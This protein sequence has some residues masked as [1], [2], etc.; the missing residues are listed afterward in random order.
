MLPEQLEKRPSID[1]EKSLA[2][3][4]HAQLKKFQ[5][6]L[7]DERFKGKLELGNPQSESRWN[8]T[9]PEEVAACFKPEFSFQAD[10]ITE[11]SLRIDDSNKINGGLSLHLEL[12]RNNQSWIVASFG[13]LTRNNCH[14]GTNYLDCLAPQA[15]MSEGRKAIENLQAKLRGSVKENYGN[16]SLNCL[17]LTDRMLDFAVKETVRQLKQS[18]KI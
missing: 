10:E 5:E 13:A 4:L 15:Q 18:P 16:Y 9:M 6:L 8:V 14:C 2:I 3:D 17:R 1:E 11:V 12:K 7:G